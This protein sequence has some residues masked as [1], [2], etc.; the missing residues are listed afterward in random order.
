MKLVF[1]STLTFCFFLI[2]VVSANLIFYENFESGA[3]NENNWGTAGAN[4]GLANGGTISDKQ[5]HSGKK[6]WWIGSMNGIYHLVEPPLKTATVFVYFYDNADEKSVNALV[7]GCTSETSKVNGWPI[8]SGNWMYM[9]LCTT[10]PNC[11]AY[12]WRSAEDGEICVGDKRKTGWHMFVYV[13]DQGKLNAYIDGEKLEDCSMSQLGNLV[14]FH[15]WS[16]AQFL[17][18]GGFVDDIYIFS[19]KMDPKK[20]PSSAVEPG[21][22]LTVAWGEMKR[23]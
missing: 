19:T 10:G 23:Q 18:E 9:G 8:A 1:F 2:G 20:E 22:K 12:Y 17:K 21:G 16:D 14:I 4:V 3:L 11:A 7:I 13:I 5:A 15:H 6:S